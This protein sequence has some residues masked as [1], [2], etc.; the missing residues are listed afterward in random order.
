MADRNL[1][2]GVLVVA[3]LHQVHTAVGALANKVGNLKSPNE[4]VAFAFVLQLL[5]I[6]HLLK[7]SSDFLQLLFGS[8]FVELL[9]QG[10]VGFE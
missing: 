4:L 9:E 3:A 10:N 7:V 5:K 2:H 1:L 6:S 8:F